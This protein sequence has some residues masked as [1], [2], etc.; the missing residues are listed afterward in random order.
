MY[1]FLLHIGPMDD[2]VIDFSVLDPEAGQ[3]FDLRLTNNIQGA[4]P[5]RTSFNSLYMNVPSGPTPSTYYGLVFTSQRRLIVATNLTMVGTKL[6][7]TLGETIASNGTL[8]PNQKPHNERKSYVHTSANLLPTAV[9][10]SNIGTFRLTDAMRVSGDFIVT[11]TSVKTDSC[12][13]TFLY[14]LAS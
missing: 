6:F 13:C 2:A 7:A 12:T 8:A 4:N 1:S 11:N 10:A 5:N 9:I 3:S 14:D